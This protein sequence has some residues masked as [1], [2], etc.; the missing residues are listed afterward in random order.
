LEKAVK[1]RL[2]GWFSE[3]L[4]EQYCGLIREYFETANAYHSKSQK[5]SEI[6]GATGYFSAGL[7]FVF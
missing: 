3:W 2:L 7:L 5:S 1:E 6:E 4:P